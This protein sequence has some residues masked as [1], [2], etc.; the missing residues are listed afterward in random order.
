[1]A[2]PLIPPPGQR[3]QPPSPT[4]SFRPFPTLSSF[5]RTSLIPHQNSPPFPLFFPPNSSQLHAAIHA[6]RT[7]RDCSAQTSLESDR[8]ACCS[9]SQDVHWTGGT[10]GR[11]NFL[12]TFKFI[13]DELNAICL[14]TTSECMLERRQLDDILDRFDACMVCCL[15]TLAVLCLAEEIQKPNKGYPTL[16]ELRVEAITYQILVCVLVFPVLTDLVS[17]LDLLP[18][19]ESS[20]CSLGKGPQERFHPEW[21]GRVACVSHHRVPCFKGSIVDSWRKHDNPSCRDD[22]R[23]ALFQSSRTP[24]SRS[25]I[26]H[27]GKQPILNSFLSSRRPSL[28]FE[29]RAEVSVFRLIA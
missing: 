18:S 3:S 9:Q 10:Q 22:P 25:R 5:L 19:P 26:K 8:N 6:L 20:V 15:G 29:Q 23:C 4:V 16:F 21:H 7:P 1:M 24:Q 13:Y 27:A 12:K 11:E 14:T 2:C 17:I 28:A